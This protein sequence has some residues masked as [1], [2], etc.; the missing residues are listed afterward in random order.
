MKT[1]I[2][3]GVVGFLSGLMAI[4]PIWFVGDS[5]A[6]PGSTEYL[7]YQMFNRIMAFLLAF[8]M[9][10]IFAFLL[11]RQ[12]VLTRVDKR[13]LTIA[14][15]AW[16]A[17]SIGTAAEFW[18]YSDLPYPRSPADFNMRTAAFALFLL[19]SLIAGVANLLLAL[20]PSTSNV[21]SHIFRVILV[22]HLPLFVASFP[23]G[24]SIFIAPA[25]ASMAVAVLALI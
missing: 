20:R 24:F 19:G 8:Q 7:R 13:V 6:L 1:V 16:A 2:P 23:V 22:L 15:V 4:V 21:L 11:G 25:L 10:S 3:L 18:L 14:L 9:C 5:F 17:M 12:A